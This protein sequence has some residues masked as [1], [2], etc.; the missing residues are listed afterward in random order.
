MLAA[1]AAHLCN[2]FGGMGLT[3]G[4]ADVAGLAQ[5]FE[6]IHSGQAND[7]DIL[8]IWS[9]VQMKKWHN[10]INPV[11]SGNIRRL[12][13][14]DPD[15]ALEA[16]EFLK[17]LKKAES[18]PALSEELQSAGNNLNYDYSQHFIK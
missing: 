6:G 2:P 8:T 5:C 4:I 3:G 7:D 13:D 18:D 17:T 12:F 9:D 14:Q 1:D 16:D 15:K 11:S 10:I